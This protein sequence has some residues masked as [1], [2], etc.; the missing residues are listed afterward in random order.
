MSSSKKGFPFSSQ[1]VVGAAVLGAAA[2]AIRSAIRQ[3][4]RI[5]FTGKT[6][7]VSGASRGFGLDL[8]RGFAEEG[9]DLILLARG[10]GNLAQSANKLRGY[11][12]NVACRSVDV[13]NRTQVREAVGSI[14]AERHNI[15]VL[16]NNAGTIQV[17]PLENMELEDYEAALRVHFWGPLYL[18][19]EIIPHMKARRQGR[20]VNIASI[21]A[22]VAV[23]HLVPYTA[24][25]FA[26]AG[27][28]QAMRAEL[29]KDGIYV[30]T[31]SPGLMRTGS[32]LNAS[33]KGQHRKEY[34]LFSIANAFLSISSEDAARQTIDACRYG[35]AELVISAQARLL[36]LA[37]S[38]FPG[39]VSET[40]GLL[41]RALPRTPGRTG[42]T[43]RPG[44]ESQ[45]LIAPSV[46]TRSADDAA[47]NN[48]EILSS[49]KSRPAGGAAMPTE[50]HADDNRSCSCTHS[51]HFLGRCQNAVELSGHICPACME[52]H[53]HRVDDPAI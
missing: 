9:A 11:G 31:V 24:S 38:L 47:L 26:L 32:H 19:Q 37:N 16:I 22:K 17:G 14:L 8:A 28:S 23:P 39:L 46:L 34:A 29:L 52:T 45:S 2:Y 25:K 18:M 20:I 5:D 4:R 27:L 1:L 3:R 40:M 33:F 42:D 35:D 48:N 53:F 15:D 10:D 12:V 21:G 51:T 50:R 44:F 6:V 49:R 13:G 41:N 36:R 43:S 30:T 7:L